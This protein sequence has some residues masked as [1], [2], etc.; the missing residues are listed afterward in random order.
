R[1]TYECLKWSD[2]GT[3]VVITS[4]N[5]V[6][7]DVLT[8][9]FDTLK[10]DSF[11]RQFHIYE[12]IR[13]TDNRRTKHPEGYCEFY[14][15]NFQRGRPD[16]LSLI[17]RKKASRSL[18]SGEALSERNSVAQRIRMSTLN[19][20]SE[21]PTMLPTDASSSAPVPAAMFRGMLPANV[22]ASVNSDAASYAEAQIA[23]CLRI[24]TLNA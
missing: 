6:I 12:F 15:P 3:R 5:A 1:G 23:E 11:T 13:T 9:H 20:G 10:F 19:D 7:K 17:P 24:P 18:A 16:L 2:D 4:R 14:Q 8:N 22:V 21:P